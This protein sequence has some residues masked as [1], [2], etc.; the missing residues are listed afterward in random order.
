[1]LHVVQRSYAAFGSSCAPDDVITLGAADSTECEHNDILMHE[2][3]ARVGLPVEPEK[4]EG[5]TTALSFVGI[6]L[7]S[8][9]MT[10]EAQTPKESPFRLEGKKTWQEERARSDI[11]WWAQYAG[12]RNGIQMMRA[13]K[14][15][16][17]AVVVTS[18]A[19]GNW[20]CGAYSGPSWFMLK[21]AVPISDCHISARDGTHRHLSGHLGPFIARKKCSGQV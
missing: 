20:G 7:D 17:S 18:D 3:C 5:P 10:G 9:A 15:V 8:M 16:T 12:P 1:M 19:S 14:G 6:E 21:W 4:D 13:V 2:A 11:E